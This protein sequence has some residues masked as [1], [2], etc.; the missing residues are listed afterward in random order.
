MNEFYVL[1]KV[2]KRITGIIFDNLSY[3]KPDL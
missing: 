3:A 2:R 1:G